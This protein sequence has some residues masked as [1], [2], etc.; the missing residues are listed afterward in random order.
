MKMVNFELE[1]EKMQGLGQLLLFYPLRTK[2]DPHLCHTLINPVSNFI[3]LNS[4]L[5][6]HCLVIYLCFSLGRNDRNKKNLSIL[7]KAIY[8]HYVVYFNCLLSITFCVSIFCS[9]INWGLIW[10]VLWG[11][12]S[13]WRGNGCWH[14]IQVNISSFK[15]SIICFRCYWWSQ[16]EPRWWSLTGSRL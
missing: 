4:L 13:G 12:G 10:M 1:F 3:S 7:V 5:H 6:L 16:G 9:G 11:W 8:V 14:D 2:P 15:L